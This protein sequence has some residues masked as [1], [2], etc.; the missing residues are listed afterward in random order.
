MNTIL[1]V[2]DITTGYENNKILQKVSFS[3]KKGE[4]VGI[5]GRNGAGK[6]TL[7]KALRGFL[8]LRQGSI[9]LFDKDIKD[10]Q[11]RE[12]AAQIAYLQQ[13]IELTFDYTAKDMVMAGRYPYINWWEQ[14]GDDDLKIIEACMEYTGVSD[15][16]DTPIRSMSGGQR[17]RVLLAKVLAQQTPVLFLDEPAAGLDL[18]YQEEIFRFCQEMCRRGKTVIM[19][20]HE[21]NLAARY[22]SRVILLHNGSVFADAEPEK[23]LTDG[24]LSEAYGV[25]ICSMKNPQTG[26]ADIFTVPVQADVRKRQLLDTIVGAERMGES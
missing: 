3:V 18:F 19:V 5:I 9:I 1:K 23:V 25:D 20:V 13:Q 6:S 7:L 8:P 24:L 11:Q 17:Q 22:C 10:Y 16:A 4:F 14:Q 12:M 26:H 2:N 15:L 21:L